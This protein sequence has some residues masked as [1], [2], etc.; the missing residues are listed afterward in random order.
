MQQLTFEQ[1]KKKAAL[2]GI[3]GGKVIIGIWARNNGY[4]KS[5]KQINKK[6]VALYFKC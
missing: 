4:I 5:I 1:I 6:K 2:D 3:T